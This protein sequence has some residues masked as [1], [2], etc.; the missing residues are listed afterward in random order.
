MSFV[1]TSLAGAPAGSAVAVDPAGSLA[2]NVTNVQLSSTRSFTMF[3]AL[4]ADLA[5]AHRK[6][7]QQEFQRQLERRAQ[8]EMLQALPRLLMR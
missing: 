5:R 7:R 2:T 8:Q 4:Y 6:R 1:A 3:Q